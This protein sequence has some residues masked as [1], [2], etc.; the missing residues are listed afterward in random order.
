MLRGFWIALIASVGLASCAKAPST[1]P[2]LPTLPAGAP[3][4]AG[5]TLP[6]G[7]I[8]HVIF[9]IQENRTFDN[10]FGGRS[11]PDPSRPLR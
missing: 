11:I 9:V 2:A 8:T 5:S 3:T 6:T 7:K 10:I 4:K 1:G